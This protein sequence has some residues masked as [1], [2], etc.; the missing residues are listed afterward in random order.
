MNCFVRKTFTHIITDVKQVNTP[1]VLGV[2]GTR[3]TG[4]S[5]SAFEAGTCVSY[6]QLSLCDLICVYSNNADI[7]RYTHRY[8][9]LKKGHSMKNMYVSL[10]LPI[11]LKLEKSQFAKPVD[12]EHTETRTHR[13]KST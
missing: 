12:Q 3:Q 11:N 6:V 4:H 1:Q 7:H 13:D 5:F 8:T 2:K 9:K 10:F